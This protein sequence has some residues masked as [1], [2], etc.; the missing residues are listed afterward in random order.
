MLVVEINLHPHFA[1]NAVKN[2][3]IFFSPH[4]PKAFGVATLSH[5]TQSLVTSSFFPFHKKE[6]QIHL[7][8]YRTPFGIHAM[9]IQ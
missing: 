3:Y 4:P 2:L 1:T 6:K 5:L 8:I 9:D 7:I